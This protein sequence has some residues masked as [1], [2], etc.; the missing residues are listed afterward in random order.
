MEIF[1]SNLWWMIPNIALASLGFVFGL[2]YLHSKQIYLKMPFF[3]LWILFFPNTIYLLTDFEHLLTQFSQVNFETGLLL[4]LQYSILMILGILTYFVGMMP[5]E[6]YFKSLRKSKKTDYRIIFVLL[7]FAVAFAVVL[8]KAERTHSFYIFTQPIRVLKDAI[9][10]LS[11]PILFGSVVL[12]GI[13]F[14]LFYF[15]FKRRFSKL[16]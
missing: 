9:A 7:N 16:K 4:I 13:V 11:D 3:I 15:A 1:Y 6:D 12:L 8:G 14:N 10:V 5:I 2:L